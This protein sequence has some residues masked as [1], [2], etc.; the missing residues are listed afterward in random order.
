MLTLAHTNTNTLVY[1]VLYSLETTEPEV[2]AKTL[3]RGVGVA[4]RVFEG[5]YSV[6]R[7]EVSE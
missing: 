3:S 6:C 1:Q 7:R 2:L 5:S 4:K